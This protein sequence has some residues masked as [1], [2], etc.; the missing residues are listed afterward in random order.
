MTSHLPGF[1]KLRQIKYDLMQSLKIS[2]SGNLTKC[3]ISMEV[4]TK[5]V[6]FILKLGYSSINHSEHLSLFFVSEYLAVKLSAW[7]Y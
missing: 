4:T 5:M 7:L 1:K 2:T 6:K 3:I